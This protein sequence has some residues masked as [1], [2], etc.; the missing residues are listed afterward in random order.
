MVFF[1]L[2]RSTKFAGD[3]TCCYLLFDTQASG[4]GSGPNR[5]HQ[6]SGPGW[7]KDLCHQHKAKTVSSVVPR[8]P[9]VG[10]CDV[11]TTVILILEVLGARQ[12]WPQAEGDAGHYTI[13]FPSYMRWAGQSRFPAKKTP[14]KQRYLRLCKNGHFS[15]K[16]HVSS[17]GFSYAPCFLSLL[18]PKEM[19]LIP[20]MLTF[21]SLQLHKITASHSHHF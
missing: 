14:T 7:E 12:Q 15:Y 10:E 13:M 21:A 18:F 19:G 11:G 17:P 8:W 6:S 3:N 2:C 9:P 4:E 1:P 5:G 16:I 20:A